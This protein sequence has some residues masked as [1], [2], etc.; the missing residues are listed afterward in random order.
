ML[1]QGLKIQLHILTQTWLNFP[2]QRHLSIALP[3]GG[4]GGGGGGVHNIW[5]SFRLAVV[6]PIIKHT[7]K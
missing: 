3:W 4:G 2:P 1:G 7:G 5:Q 6:Y